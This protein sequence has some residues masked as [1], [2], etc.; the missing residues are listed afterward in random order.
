MVHTEDL[1]QTQ[2]LPYGGELIQRKLNRFKTYMSENVSR[3]V[4][5]RQ[6]SYDYS[7]FFHLHLHE[8]FQ[9]QLVWSKE[10]VSGLAFVRTLNEK[11]SGCFFFY[12]YYS[13][14]LLFC[15]QLFFFL[16]F[17][18]TLLKTNSINLLKGIHFNWKS[19]SF[20]T[21]IYLFSSLKHKIRCWA[22]CSSYTFLYNECWR[23]FILP[24][25]K[26]DKMH[27]KICPR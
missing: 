18:L 24:S 2:S 6:V 25:S 5:V 9:C 11:T 20:K 1:T 23:W 21:C 8:T 10:F 27:L 16:F 26:K 13:I 12:Y 7:G 3:R 17:Y 14:L 22:G 15:G 4:S 19:H